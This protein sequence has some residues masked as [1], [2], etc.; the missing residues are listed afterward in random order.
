MTKARNVERFTAIVESLSDVTVTLVADCLGGTMDCGGVAAAIALA[1]IGVSVF[2]V[3]LVGEDD[4]GQSILYR[5]HEH[6]ISTSGI[7]KIKSYVTPTVTA[8]ELIHG[9]HPA[10]LNVIEHARKFALASDAMYVCDH[11]VGAAS[12]RVL[13]FI[14]SNGCVKDKTLTA[15]SVHRLAS[16]EQLT[17]AVAGEAEIAETIG[18]ALDGDENKIAIAGDGFVSEMQLESFL[19]VGARHILAFA[20]GHK[21]A[22]MALPKPLNLDILGALFAAALGAAAETIEAAE[23]AAKVSEFLLRRPKKRIRRDDLLK[24]LART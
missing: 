16:F 1:E 6:R 9:E 7:S 8:G 22:R 12:P 20:E 19:A 2:P 17:A 14:K 23:V 24:F 21:P 10:L 18:I 3:G 4:A 5:L 15:R 11:G 13:N